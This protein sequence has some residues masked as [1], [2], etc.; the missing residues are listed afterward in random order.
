MKLTIKVT[1]AFAI[2]CGLMAVG[3]AFSYYTWEK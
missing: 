2:L 3:G 1:I